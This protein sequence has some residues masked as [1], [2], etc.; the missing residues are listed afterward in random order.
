ML[1]LSGQGRLRVRQNDSVQ[2]G[3]WERQRSLETDYCHCWRHGAWY[4]LMAGRFMP[5][6]LREPKWIGSARSCGDM[7]LRRFTI[8]ME[9]PSSCPTWLSGSD[10][11]EV[12]DIGIGSALSE[13]S[14]SIMAPTREF[15]IET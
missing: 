5:I 10:A 11:S 12:A 2:G 6:D 1:L 14:A 4:T 15:S 8:V 9:L 3:A 7:A 13:R